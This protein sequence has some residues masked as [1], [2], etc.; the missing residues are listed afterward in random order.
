MNR[1]CII[2]TPR[3]GSNYLEDM[4]YQRIL[5]CGD[6]GMKLGEILH[7]I[8][9]AY[10]DTKHKQFRYDS[11]Y[12]STERTNFR[13]DIFSKLES[14]ASAG[15]TVRVFVQ[16]HHALGIDYKEFIEKL[17]SLNFK[18]I[19]LTRNCIDSTISLVMAQQ[20]GLWH[21]HIYNGKI[22]LID[23]NK[24]Y[25]KNPSLVNI[26][27]LEFGK[28]YLEIKF[29]DYYNRNILKDIDY[30]TVRY[31]NILEDCKTNNIPVT[32]QVTF[33]KLHNVNYKDLIVNYEEL[34][35]F[36]GQIINGR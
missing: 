11:L 10:S 1:W 23:G 25:A 20:T 32:E 35:N 31:E 21:R 13:N 33:K 2:A 16:E 28:S 24:E 19:H 6:F 7:R 12:N 17:K 36:Y 29:H 5:N 15:A 30:V 26:P 27:L 14:D 8:I 22:E 3:S 34:Q 4:I 9:W 18:F